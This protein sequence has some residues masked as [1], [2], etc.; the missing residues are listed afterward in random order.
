MHA[1]IVRNSQ[2]VELTAAKMPVTVSKIDLSSL[3]VAAVDPLVAEMHLSMEKEVRMMSA[4]FRERNLQQLMHHQV[5]AVDPLVAEMHVSMEKEV[6]MMSTP[7]RVRVLQQLM[8]H[9]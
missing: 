7:F 9:Q 2:P 5:T 1:Y 6:R 8:H 3:K 4:A